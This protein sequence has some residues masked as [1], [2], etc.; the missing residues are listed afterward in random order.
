LLF[1]RTWFKFPVH[2]WWL[3]TFYN[4]QGDP[5][6]SSGLQGHTACTRCTGIYTSRTPIHRK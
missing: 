3:T 5:M 6:T 2:I 1:Q 4:F